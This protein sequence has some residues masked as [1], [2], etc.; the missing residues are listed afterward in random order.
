MH[1]TL[2]MADTSGPSFGARDENITYNTQLYSSKIFQFFLYVKKLLVSDW[3]RAVH[4]S[5]TPVQKVYH[6]C[7]LHIVI[8]DY[9]CLKEKRK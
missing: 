8:L 1:S 7:K 4:S 9:A 3:L 6:Q 5:V 2:V